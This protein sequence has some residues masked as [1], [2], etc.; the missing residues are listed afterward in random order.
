[1]VIFINGIQSASSV[2]LTGRHLYRAALLTR[3]RMRNLRGRTQSIRDGT[4]KCGPCRTLDTSIPPAPEWTLGAGRGRGTILLQWQASPVG[5]YR[6]IIFNRSAHHS[7]GP[8]SAAA[9]HAPY[10]RHRTRIFLP[11]TAFLTIA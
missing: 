5:P 9:H 11:R 2:L 3:A 10:Q 8:V 1:V 6:A 4:A 7:P